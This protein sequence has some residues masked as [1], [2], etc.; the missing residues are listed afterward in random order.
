MNNNEKHDDDKSRNRSEFLTVS[1]HGLA[2][3]MER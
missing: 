2:R 1:F 3:R